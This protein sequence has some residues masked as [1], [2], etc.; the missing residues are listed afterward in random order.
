MGVQKRGERVGD[1]GNK[2]KKMP[3]MGK[4]FHPWE[5]WEGGEKRPNK[6]IQKHKDQKG[7]NV[8]PWVRRRKVPRNIWIVVAPNDPCRGKQP[9]KKKKKGWQKAEAQHKHIA[10]KKNTVSEAEKRSKSKN[11]WG[12]GGEEQDGA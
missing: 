5:L 7:E 8:Y 3:N 4:A 11:W 2:K 6:R 9:G 1:T 10:K 12:W